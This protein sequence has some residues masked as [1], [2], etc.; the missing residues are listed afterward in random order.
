MYCTVKSRQKAQLRNTQYFW[1]ITIILVL[2]LHRFAAI[3]KKGAYKGSC[4]DVELLKITLGP[5]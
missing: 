1:P 4:K 5:Q 2:H 3:I